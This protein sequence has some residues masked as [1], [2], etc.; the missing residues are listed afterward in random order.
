M[1]TPKGWPRSKRRNSIPQETPGSQSQ[2]LRVPGALPSVSSELSTAWVR[3]PRARRHQVQQI[4]FPSAGPQRAAASSPPSL[5][6]A[7]PA[8]CS[9]P[10]ARVAAAGSEDLVDA[11]PWCVSPPSGGRQALPGISMPPSA[12]A[13]CSAGAGLRF[14]S[15]A[16]AVAATV[17]F[18]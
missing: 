4:P 18:R 7:G 14:L 10:A 11:V 6:P 5:L 13:H 9:G 12:P 15:A 1:K 17:S 8:R 3:A 16:V 2:P